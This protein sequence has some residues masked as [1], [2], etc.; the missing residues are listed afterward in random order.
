VDFPDDLLA[1]LDIALNEAEWHDVVL[2][3]D[4]AE[5]ML[6]F[7]VL[8][9]PEVGPEPS[10]RDRVLKLLLSEVGRVAA[11]LRTGHWDDSAAPVQSFDLDQLSEVVSSFGVQ[12]I[13]GW[14]FFDP[15][16]SSWEHWRD[17]LS[18]DVHMSAGSEAPGQHVLDVFKES[19]RGPSRTLDLRLWFNGLSGYD[20]D[21]N[22]KPLL[23]VAAAGL[24]WWD[25]FHADDPRT[26]GHGIV[27]A[28]PWDREGSAA[29]GT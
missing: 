7:R 4:I 29:P 13:Y 1:H 26:Q 18:L 12:P 10:E 25:G 24:R 9:L 28:G 14:Q 15:P 3:R 20:I 17:R 23:E 11:S 21:N 2:R 8:A 19:L 22:P 6:V 5:A 16:E 27:K